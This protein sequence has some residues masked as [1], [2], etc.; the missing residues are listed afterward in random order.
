[1]LN[2]ETII[3]LII[4]ILF[5]T[6]LLCIIKGLQG[7]ITL[8]DSYTDLILTFIIVI[9]PFLYYY[10]FFFIFQKSVVN[11]TFAII[12][13]ILLFILSRVTY[14]S[15]DRNVFITLCVM[16]SK[17]ILSFIFV[18]YLYQ[19]FNNKKNKSSNNISNVFASIIVTPMLTKFV[20][21]R[22]YKNILVIEKGNV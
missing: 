3:V 19:L 2:T 20:K 12:E 16:F 7:K 14:K 18:F 1:M 17:L 11:I 8:F 9:F 13:L 6:F 15:N 10:I 21:N 22:E 5:L 4:G